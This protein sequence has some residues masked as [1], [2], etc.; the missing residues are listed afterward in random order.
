MRNKFFSLLAAGTMSL[1][2][3]FGLSAQSAVEK[4]R[5]FSPHPFTKM[6][7]V[8]YETDI[9]AIDIRMRPD[10][11]TM[12][13]FA[14]LSSKAE[15]FG[16]TLRKIGIPSPGMSFE[17]PENGIVGG[18]FKVHVRFDS[19]HLWEGDEKQ[20]IGA[21]RVGIYNGDDSSSFLFPII[22]ARQP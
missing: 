11:D 2:I 9:R 6:N 21:L 12:V 8:V 7:G 22:V 15:T 14:I 17:E 1:M 10:R 13:T 16:F 19:K 18:S 5:V 4:S 3:P 20:Y